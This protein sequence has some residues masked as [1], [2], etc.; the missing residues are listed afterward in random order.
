MYDSNWKKWVGI[1]MFPQPILLKVPYKTVSLV[2][3]LCRKY[4][5]AEATVEAMNSVVEELT[6]SIG[7]SS[8]ISEWKKLERVAR[9]K[10]GEV[11]MIYV[12][13]FCYLSF[14]PHRM[15]SPITGKEIRRPH[16]DQQKG[17]ACSVVIGRFNPR[18]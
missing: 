18:S 15:D 13:N 2:A 7:N 12:F 8:W 3:S 5:K 9:I 11:L 1:G 14:T 16:E 10:R 6:K 17:Q 4:E